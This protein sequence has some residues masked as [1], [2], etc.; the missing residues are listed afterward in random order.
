MTI[1][2]WALLLMFAHE[3]RLPVAAV[4]QLLLSEDTWMVYP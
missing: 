4:T 3:T 1:F 2:G